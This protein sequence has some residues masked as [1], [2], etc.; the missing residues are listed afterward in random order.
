MADYKEELRGAAA[1]IARTTRCV[2]FCG[3]G[4]SAESGIATFRD[5]GGLWDRL[6]PIAV[7]DPDGFIAA[8]AKNPAPMMSVFSDLLDA[9]E[10]AEFNP[11]HRALAVLE[12]KGI[13]KTIITQ[14]IDNLQL[15]AGSRNVIE[16]HGNLFRMACL[17]CGKKKK[18]ERKPFIAGI[19]E[20]LGR[21]K[22][23]SLGSLLTLVPLCDACNSIMR[24]DV[25]MFGEAVK[26][27][28]HAFASIQDCDV[29]LALGTSGTVYPAA[30]IPFESK[31]KGAAVIVINP[32][33]NS[34]ESVSDIY[35]PMKTGE[36]LPLIVKFIE[37]KKYS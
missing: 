5:P 26:D 2:A 22:D 36:A 34:F 15:E 10:K 29:V 25:V 30:E 3:S 11:G 16:V 17:S 14:N 20:R 37:E 31:R 13:L 9:F 32:T 8:L 23:H 4:V 12:E 7:G 28:S 19:R 6:D 1:L 35:I 21:L 24:P 27:L 18:F 33:E